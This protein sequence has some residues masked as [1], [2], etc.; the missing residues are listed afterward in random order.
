MASSTIAAA[1]A[2]AFLIVVTPGPAVLAVL[3]IGAA[4]GRLAGWAF[5]TGHLVGD[6][7]WATAALAALVGAR[8]IAP[9]LFSFLAIACALYLAWLGIGLVLTKRGAGEGP[10]PIARR[11]LWRGMVFG[12]T[13]P[14]SYPVTLSIFAGLLAND[15]A[16]LTAESTPVLLA[17]LLAGFVLGDLLLVWLVGAPPLVR[18]YRRHEL[19]IVRA[20]GVLFLGFA[21]FTFVEGVTGLG[22]T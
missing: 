18:L 4:Q 8:V 14:K 6:M 20:T 15:F 22:V 10:R 1:A 17:S 13:N 3:S 16:T 9:E 5:L 2:A 7:L 21:A 11:P 12:V 19:L